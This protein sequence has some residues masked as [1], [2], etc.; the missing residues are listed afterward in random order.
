MTLTDNSERIV[1][2][3]SS[4]VTTGRVGLSA[5]GPA[6]EAAGVKGLYL[7]TILLSSRPGMGPLAKHIVPADYLS[8]ALSCLKD[9]NRLAGIDGIQTGYFAEA[10]QVGAV[11]RFMAG[12]KEER[13]DLPIL[14]DPV[15]GDADRGLFVD[16]GVANAIRDELVPLATIIVPNRFEL[17]WLTATDL[18]TEQSMVDAARGLAPPV[19]VV[20]SAYEQAGRIGTLGIAEHH[21]FSREAERFAPV[22]NGTGDLFSAL[23]MTGLLNG[24]PVEAALARSVA[25]L[26]RVA[27]AS[28]GREELDFRALGDVPP[29]KDGWVAGVDGCRTGWAAVF[30]D[31]TGRKAPRF[32]RFDTFAEILEADEEP[33]VVAVDM[34][35]GLP[36]RTGL[37]GRG[38]EAAVRP[39][40]AARQSSVFSI[41]SR[42]AVYAEDYGAACAAALAT[43]DP[44]RKVSKQGFMLFEKIRELDRL[45]TPA[46]CSRVFEVHPELAFWRLNGD[47]AMSLP[48]KVKGRANPPGLA[49]RR[50]LLQQNGFKSDFFDQARPTGVGA[51]DLLDACA[52]ALIAIRLSRGEAQSFP[53]NPERDERGL[54]VAIWA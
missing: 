48:K 47:Q 21:T 26:E 13:P 36:A 15:I 14:V 3:I 16:P 6:F 27:R 5:I 37:G 31:T 20:T 12:L 28:M 23:L 25:A 45:M 35:I 44:P 50:S 1:L 8:A 46:L 39:N 9:D 17:G 49:E 18:H 51:D 19:T 53:S 10:S 30:A 33:A 54:T 40:L 43:S 42:S 24:L 41:P 2:A 32:R 22:P 38:P 34:P 29:D 52:C 7:P 11:S 4:Q